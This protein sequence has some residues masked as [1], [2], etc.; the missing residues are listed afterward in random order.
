MSADEFDL[1]SRIVRFVALKDEA[2][3]MSCDKNLCEAQTLSLQ[4]ARH[5]ARLEAQLF[6]GDV[7]V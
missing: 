5:L 2:W 1:V 4:N 3:E 7:P 6:H